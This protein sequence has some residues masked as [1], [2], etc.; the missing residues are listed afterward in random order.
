[1]LPDFRD[2][3]KILGFPTM[4]LQFGARPRAEETIF[5]VAHAYE[6]ATEWDTMRPR[7]A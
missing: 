7:E 6:Q 5:K 3:L 4:R 1:M 2:H